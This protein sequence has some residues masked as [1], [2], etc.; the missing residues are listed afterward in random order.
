VIVMLRRPQWIRPASCLRVT[1][2]TAARRT[3]SISATE[4][5]VRPK[6]SREAYVGAVAKLMT[7]WPHRILG[8]RGRSILFQI[9]SHISIGEQMRMLAEHTLIGRRGPRDR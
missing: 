3:P 5:S 8:E 6:R 9:R 2:D 1:T 7:Y 4:R